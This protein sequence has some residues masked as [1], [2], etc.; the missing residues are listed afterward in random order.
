MTPR[1]VKEMTTHATETLTDYTYR[2]KPQERRRRAIWSRMGRLSMNNRSGH[3]S[4][5]SILRWRSAQRSIID[6]PICRRYLFSH[7]LPNIATNAAN[8]DISRLA[9][10]R[11]EVVT[12]SAG[13]PLHTGG[14]AGSS[15]G[16]MD[17]LRL[18]RIAR[19]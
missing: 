1:T 11:F 16:I 5:P 15:P 19:R 13:G 6:P 7:C 17:R 18:R 12:I 8:S 9:Y 14:T 4:R 2:D 10:R 3:F